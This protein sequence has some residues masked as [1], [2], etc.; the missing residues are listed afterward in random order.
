MALQPDPKDSPVPTEHTP[1]YANGHTLSDIVNDAVV[2]FNLYSLPPHLALNYFRPAVGIACD[3]CLGSQTRI[4]EA[5]TDLLLSSVFD[6]P[7]LAGCTCRS[8]PPSVLLQPFDR[9][10]V[11]VDINNN[12]FTSYDVLPPAFP[13]LNRHRISSLTGRPLVP[14]EV[15]PSA[16]PLMA[17]EDGSAVEDTCRTALRYL[18]LTAPII[19][20]DDHFLYYNSILA[21]RHTYRSLEE[22]LPRIRAHVDDKQPVSGI[23]PLLCRHFSS[24]V[25]IF[26]DVILP[27][28]STHEVIRKHSPPTWWQCPLFTCRS[29]APLS[30]GL[31]TVLA[32]SR[33]YLLDFPLLLDH[34]KKFPMTTREETALQSYLHYGKRIPNGRD[35]SSHTRF[36]FSFVTHLLDV[37]ATL[38]QL[39][40]YTSRRFYL[41]SYILHG[42]LF[43][44]ENNLLS[45]FRLFYED[46]E[47]Y[48]R[49]HQLCPDPS[50]LSMKRQY[51]SPVKAA[52]LAQPFLK[53]LDQRRAWTFPDIPAI[54]YETTISRFFPL[55]DFSLDAWR[56]ACPDGGISP[57]CSHA[58]VSNGCSCLNQSKEQQL[59][60]KE[61]SSHLP[62]GWPA[63]EWDPQVLHT[64]S[65]APQ[66][67]DPSPPRSSTPI[68]I[69][70]DQ[71]SPQDNHL[72][73]PLPDPPL[74]PIPPPP[75]LPRGPRSL[76]GS[77]T[78]T[79]LR[80]ALRRK[81]RNANLSHLM[82]LILF[83]LPL[84]MGQQQALRKGNFLFSRVVDVLINPAQ[85]VYV[86]RLNLKELNS[87][88]D[89]LQ[90]I[91]Q[92]YRKVCEKSLANGTASLPY[93]IFNET[94]TSLDI[95]SAC[96]RQGMLGP[97]IETSRER[98]ELQSLMARHNISQL[99][100][101]YFSNGPGR[102]HNKAYVR[103][104][105]GVSPVQP[106]LPV[107][108]A[109]TSEN[110]MFPAFYKLG[111]HQRMELFFQTTLPMDDRYNPL[112]S[113]TFPTTL[114]CRSPTSFRLP[115]AGDAIHLPILRGLCD[116][117]V[118]SFDDEIRQL[119][120]AVRNVQPKHVDTYPWNEDSRM[121]NDQTPPIPIPPQEAVEAHL[122]REERATTWPPPTS[123]H[124]RHRP[125][126][127]ATAAFL[128]GAAIALLVSQAISGAVNTEQM[129]K[130]NS[131]LS[132]LSSN[133]AEVQIFTL[134]MQQVL[135]RA[136]E[137][138][139][140]LA[141]K[142]NVMYNEIMLAMVL[143]QLYTDFQTVKGN[144][145][146]A[147]INLL[148]IVSC[149]RQG[150]PHEFVTDSEFL[151]KIQ[152]DSSD[153]LVTDPVHLQAGLVRNK[154]GFFIMI[155]VPVRDPQR[156]GNLMRVTPVP[157]YKG[158]HTF[159][160]SSYI[161]HFVAM[162][163]DYFVPLDSD[164][165]A[166]C[167]SLPMSC[168]V[169]H[170]LKPAASR[171][172][173]PSTFFGY[174]SACTFKAS[175][176]ASDFFYIVG[177]S[178]HFQLQ[179]PRTLHKHCPRKHGSPVG[180]T[181]SKYV[182][183]G[184]GSFHLEEGCYAKTVHGTKILSNTNN[185]QEIVV[186][187][188][189]HLGFSKHTTSYENF[190][191][192]D[193]P[194]FINTSRHSLLLEDISDMAPDFDPIPPWATPI[195]SP[196]ITPVLTAIVLSIFMYVLLLKRL[197]SYV[198]HRLCSDL[199]QSSFGLP[200]THISVCPK[201]SPSTPS[202]PPPSPPPP[203]PPPHSPYELQRL[204]RVRIHTNPFGSVPIMSRRHH[205]DNVTDGATLSSFRSPTPE[206]S[207]SP[208]G[209]SPE[210]EAQLE[211][212]HDL[213]PPL[214]PE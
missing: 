11:V 7:P 146:V 153:D 34:A 63:M 128:G 182:L 76:P 77:P 156:M 100:S 164:E 66:T 58:C 19:P 114:I 14:D 203:P 145:N 78:H 31:H 188:I 91:S 135:H 207:V 143:Q 49:M 141:K 6:L 46:L 42:F 205:S 88:L 119:Q 147:L 124:H 148:N 206:A 212:L 202:S 50:A 36:L 137:Q 99:V 59:L 152:E 45:Q 12:V 38:C 15:V 101:P 106:V 185:K 62:T 176:I 64:F 201:P 120:Q 75:E 32:S 90:D 79:R 74:S 65:P 173:G 1:A 155:Q 192:P 37:S 129:A 33:L 209:N 130:I 116:K 194:V 30:M 51:F 94:L 67:K 41:S 20:A 157:I 69:P 175:R 166:Q 102:L 184:A 112:T 171:S 3:T 118:D 158:N 107:P 174:K 108:A 84:I 117:E 23:L 161:S 140:D 89:T 82:L 163:E 18:C 160:P 154:E 139:K 113:S 200:P 81:P 95:D 40:A 125:K 178:T 54:R 191:V 133:L 123:L 181:A 87:S 72:Q 57:T 5:E 83:V 162:P 71:S 109:T 9:D 183:L 39:V 22:I 104:S 13:V 170:V 105:S 149:A 210:G 27:F 150:V 28:D 126:R 199:R 8:T 25:R 53:L 56:R 168:Q 142:I 86:R 98:R 195:I 2:I 169:S 85:R 172:C 131:Q 17:H 92:A 80:P 115:P 111:S 179:E 132:V 61:A 26:R 193:P 96:Q 211:P 60:R 159:L 16:L 52:D 214:P 47:P 204:R 186:E 48:T 136:A 151:Y 10:K 144:L 180:G 97:T 190:I 177:N 122:K 103:T 70:S 213:L 55:I 187:D 4:T 121:S 198:R 29:S 73:P 167:M 35:F 189:I 208:L 196:Y 21:F 165:V 43:A 134:Q 110:Q 197:K 138:Q 24:T 44:G 93:S 127:A 68:P